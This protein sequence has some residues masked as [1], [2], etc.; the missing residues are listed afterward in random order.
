MNDEPFA[1]KDLITLQDPSN[2]NK[3]NL[4]NFH[5]LKNSLKVDDD[6]KIDYLLKFIPDPLNP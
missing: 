4:N 1:R 2:T 6:G 5:H 3:N